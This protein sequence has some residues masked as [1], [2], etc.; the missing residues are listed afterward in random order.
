M[1]NDLGNLSPEERAKRVPTI[2]IH[3]L[4]YPI[5]EKAHTLVQGAEIIFGIDVMSQ[6]RFLLYGAKTLERI[7]QTGSAEMLPVI[8]IELDQETEELEMAVALVRTVKGSDDYKA[9]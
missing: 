7:A 2:S 5:G 8:A 6:R 4:T 1:A 3:A 9:G